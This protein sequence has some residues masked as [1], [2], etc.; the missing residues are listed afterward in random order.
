MFDWFL[1]LPVL[2]VALILLPFRFVGCAQIAGLRSPDPDPTSLKLF[3]SEPLVSPEFPNATQPQQVVEVEVTWRL[4][5]TA[6]GIPPVIF[7]EIITS[8]K[9]PPPVPPVLDPNMDS[10]ERL[11]G[12]SVA[13]NH[14]LVTCECLVTGELGAKATT[15][16]ASMPLGASTANVF[17]LHVN[18][19]LS[20]EPQYGSSGPFR[21]DADTP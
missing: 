16:N 8:R 7:K 19:R 13:M 6:S 10:A 9:D 20:T 11:I 21:V 17:R 3:I 5:K 1:L 2:L 4:F 18:H 14:D 15:N 12:D